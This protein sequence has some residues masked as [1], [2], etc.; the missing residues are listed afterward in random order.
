[1]AWSPLRSSSRAERAEAEA[2]EA[3]SG[4]TV[5]RPALETVLRELA[6]LVRKNDPEAENAL[7]GLRGVLKGA[8]PKE[9][10]RIAQALDLFDFRAAAKALTALAEA[11]RIPLS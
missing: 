8:R 11:E 4:N 1:M 3:G 10:E 5:D 9:V 6:E 7:E 2:A